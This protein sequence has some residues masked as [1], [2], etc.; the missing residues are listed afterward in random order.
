MSSHWL[1]D[2][3]KVTETF[4]FLRGAI[5]LT[6]IRM[7]RLFSQSVLSKKIAYSSFNG[8]FLNPFA[9]WSQD[10]NRD[11]SD[12]FEMQSADDE[13]ILMYLAS[14]ITSY[15]P[16]HSCTSTPIS[17]II[18]YSSLVFRIRALPPITVRFM[19]KGCAISGSELDLKGTSITQSTGTVLSIYHPE[20]WNTPK[21][22]AL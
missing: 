10:L 3:G 19:A 15:A 9:P 20:T 4:S 16:T 13:E 7:W 17:R 12:R 2:S 6:L 22:N 11:R 8:T 18:G 14:I 21:G 5:S 1:Q